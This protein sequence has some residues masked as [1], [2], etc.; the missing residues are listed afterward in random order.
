MYVTINFMLIQYYY[1]V[2]SPFIIQHSSTCKCRSTKHLFLLY[3]N[4]I[5]TSS[6]FL[7]FHLFADDTSIFYAGKDVNK[8]ETT[9]N[10]E[11]QNVSDWLIANKL[12]LNLTKSTFLLILPSQKKLNR[13]FE[14]KLN[15]E[16]LKEVERQNI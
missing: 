16:K 10:N 9:V 4:D 8:L 1:V 7:N 13:N 11:L 3:I 2:S 6:R 15:N 14:I 12:T 5:P